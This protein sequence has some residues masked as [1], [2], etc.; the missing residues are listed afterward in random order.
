MAHFLGCFPVG[1]NL[2][3]ESVVKGF[4]AF[5]VDDVGAPLVNANGVQCPG[6]TV[7]MGN[8]L[9]L[10]LDPL[11]PMGFFPFQESQ[12]SMGHLGPGLSYSIPAPPSINLDQVVDFGPDAGR[13]FLGHL[14]ILLGLAQQL[15]QRKTQPAVLPNVKSRTLDSPMEERVPLAQA[16]QDGRNRWVVHPANGIEAAHDCQSSTY[17]VGFANSSARMICAS[18]C[19]SIVFSQSTPKASAR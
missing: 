4:R 3:P 8:D 17:S 18:R 13:F 12:E 10:A 7:N 5:E 16:I 15:I 14:P 1:C 6:V 19:S 11:H 2:H 9:H